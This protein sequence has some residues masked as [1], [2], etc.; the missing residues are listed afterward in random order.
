[1]RRYDIIGISGPQC[2]GK[3]FA[4]E[5]IAQEYGYSQ[6]STGDLLR[7]RAKELGLDMS[8]RSLQALGCKLRKE[9][10][11]QDPLLNEALSSLSSDT[12]FTGIRTI[13]AVY[14]I[15]NAPGRILYVDAP[16]E[17][18]YERSVSRARTDH[19]SMDDFIIN[20]QIEKY[21]A[22]D[23]DISLLAIRSIANKI[24]YNRS[25]EE[26]YK[27]LLKDFIEN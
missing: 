11:G 8:R 2:S 23:T 13:D 3:D 7:A 6:V 22:G 15:I 21:G 17:V 10:D 19:V 14:S 1:M 25:S 20:D 27:R 9:N 18:R 5:Y 26:V 4:A 24:I 16:L 12:V